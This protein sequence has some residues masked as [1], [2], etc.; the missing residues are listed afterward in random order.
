MSPPGQRSGQTSGRRAA[1]VVSKPLTIDAIET[2]ACEVFCRDGFDRASLRDIA[3]HAGVSLSSIHEYFDSKA[4]LYV[5]V[6]RRLFER[7]EGQR[8]ELLLKERRNGE[9]LDLRRIVRCLLA[10]VLL[11][12]TAGGERSWTPSRLRTWYDTTAYLGDHPEFRELLR[13]A[14]ESWVRLL[15]EVCPGLDHAGGRFAY[16]LIAAATFTWE[17][18]NAYVSDTL[19]IPGRHSPD[20]EC[21]LMVEFFCAG[22]RN[23]ASPTA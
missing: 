3:S 15:C 17:T 13:Q 22:I 4:E 6:G 14:T 23:A 5:Q 8:Q 10:P 11:E 20:E 7:F 12:R 19:G 18:T 9:T 21:D 1:A 2:S 16:A